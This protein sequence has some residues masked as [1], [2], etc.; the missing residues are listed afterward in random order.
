MESEALIEF[1]KPLE[2]IKT[3]TPSPQGKEV[4]LK[5]TYGGVCHS[6]VHIQDGYFDLGGGNQLPL[7]GTMNLPHTLGHEIEGE[8]VSIGSD[9]K[10]IKVGENVV[11]FPWIGCG[12]CA[13]CDSGDEHLC[14]APRQLGIQLAGGFSDYC[15]VPD[16]KYLLDYTGIKPGLAA[17]YM[18]SGLTAF[19]ALKKINHV[20][21]DDHILILGLGGV[22]MLSLIHI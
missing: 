21:K 4:L 22:G 5:V 6:D 19:G 16:E 7:G 3:E 2:R 20:S 14:N 15:L 1:G 18:C 13:T 9:V 10:D 11:A 8:V 12:K 17:T